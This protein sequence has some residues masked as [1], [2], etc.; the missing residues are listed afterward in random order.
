MTLHYAIIIQTAL[1][2]LGLVPAY[3]LGMGTDMS[4]AAAN[5]TPRLGAALLLMGLALPVS[6]G[7]SLAL[8][9]IAHL[10][11]WERAALFFVVFPWLHLV[12]LIG[13]M[14]FMFRQQGRG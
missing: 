7:I 5:K 14:L 4:A 2:L 13:G 9:W 10:L 6:L 11:G 12:S 1:G 3:L 8:M